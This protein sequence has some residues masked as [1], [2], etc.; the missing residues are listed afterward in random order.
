[1]LNHINRI[2][3]F[4]ALG[5]EDPEGSFLLISSRGLGDKETI[6]EREFW[7]LVGP[8]LHTVCYETHETILNSLVLLI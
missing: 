2:L 7:D 1:M 8:L 4:S 3:P 6:V 5:K